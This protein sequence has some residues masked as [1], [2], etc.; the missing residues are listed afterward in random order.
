MAKYVKLGEKAESYSSPQD[1]IKLIKGSAVKLPNRPSKKVMDAIKGGHLVEIGEYEFNLMTGAIQ[2]KPTKETKVKAK[3]KSA[4]EKRLEVMDD[5]MLIDY[6]KETFEVTD[7][8]IEE[9]TQKSQENKV[10]YILEL[11]D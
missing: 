5:D 4:L 3:P 10:A 1:K 9:F 8:V 7:E 11:E 6:L 2:P